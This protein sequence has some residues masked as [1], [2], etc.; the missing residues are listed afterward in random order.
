MPG[1]KIGIITKRDTSE[2]LVIDSYIDANVGCIRQRTF[3]FRRTTLRLIQA[4]SKYMRKR[5]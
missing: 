5:S 2:E 4:E 1:G 3:D